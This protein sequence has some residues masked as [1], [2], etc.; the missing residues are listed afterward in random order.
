MFI[1]ALSAY[2]ARVAFVLRCLRVGVNEQDFLC[3]VIPK[4]LNSLTF[5]SVIPFIL[6]DVLIFWLP[7][8]NTILLV[9]EWLMVSL[10]LSQYF[11]VISSA[12]CSPS[13]DFD[14]RTMSSAY[15]NALK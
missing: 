12:F 1:L 2:S 11:S 13:F 5:S 14:N 3:T 9:F 8:E 4:Y 10:H 6:N 7:G 15:A